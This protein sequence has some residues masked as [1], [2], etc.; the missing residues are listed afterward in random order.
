VRNVR[1]NVFA[2]KY[3]KGILNYWSIKLIIDFT[4]YALFES[5]TVRNSVF[6]LEKDNT[7]T[8]IKYL[9][10]ND[11]SLNILEFISQPVKLLDSSQ[12]S[13]FSQ[14][15]ALSFKLPKE[16]IKVIT[17]IKSASNSLN[18]FFPDISQGLIAYD[19]YRGQ[20][21]K[22][23]ESRT[24]HFDSFKEGLKKWLWGEDIT[25]YKIEWNAKEYIDYCDGIANPRKPKYFNNKRLL[26]REITNPTIF[27][28]ITHLEFYNDPAII[29]VLDNSDYSLEAVSLI[30]NSKLGSFIHFNASP[31]ATKGEFPKI[32]VKDIKEFPISKNIK[33]MSHLLYRNIYFIANELISSDFYKK[34]LTHI[35]DAIV[36]ELYFP[37]HMKERKI[38]ILQFVE[39]DIEEIMQNKEF[40]SLDN[41]QKEHVITELHTRWSDPNSEIVKR[42][43]SFAEKSP[44]IL[45]PILEG[46]K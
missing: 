20:N 21:S 31:K 35:I 10:T 19:K 7:S 41:T 3:R 22:I 26:I 16:T 29:I 9:P 44:E 38:D 4:S 2:E 25:K 33:I 28:A 12:L 11:D 27:S 8:D 40:E 24:Y 18:Q 37:E 30:L 39:K 15:W 45:K 34:L 23:I 17:K 36:F 13:L 32:L 46:S 42:M 1:F 43:N 14:N 6:V 5:A